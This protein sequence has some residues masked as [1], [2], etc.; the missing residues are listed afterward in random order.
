MG[1]NLLALEFEIM[2]ILFLVLVLLAGAFVVGVVLFIIGLVTRY[3]AKKKQQEKKY[4]KVLIGISLPILILP[5]LAV[6]F[7]VGS[8][9]VNAVQ[10]LIKYQSEDTIF[11]EKV[12]A[13]FAEADAGDAEA[14]YDLF[15]ESEKKENPLLREQIDALLDEYP[16][17]PD[18]NERDGAG[19]SSGSW[20]DGLEA[21]TASDGFAITKDGVRYYCF[22]EYTYIDETDLDE[23]GIKYVMIR[24]EK[25]YFDEEFE[26]PEVDGIYI[27]LASDKSYETRRIG[28]YPEIFVSYDRTITEEALRDF[29]A[30]STNLS[31]FK[32]KFG[33]PNADDP[34]LVCVYQI[35]GNDGKR[36]YAKL[37]H[38]TDEDQ[39]LDCSDIVNNVGDYYSPLF[40][41]KETGDEEPEE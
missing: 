25:V 27:Q 40:E 22:M 13:F 11:N 19:H 26:F 39:I 9:V 36:Y 24:S 20:D 34:N 38:D 21:T 31:E 35:K 1:E 29:L 14:I 23:V 28:G 2:A 7:F 3:R 18:T 16:E 17:S 8:R 5:V 15:A 10:N 30:K 32:E 41:E 6:G 4:P 37:Y 12:D 33:E